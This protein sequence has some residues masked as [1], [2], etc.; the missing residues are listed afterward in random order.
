MKTARRVLGILVLGML[1]I[2]LSSLTAEAAGGPAKPPRVF[3]VNP[4]KVNLNVQ[5]S[6][7]LIG[8]NL[9]PTTRVAIGGVP[10]TTVEAPDTYHLLVRLPDN[11][12]EGIYTVTAANESGSTTAEQ[13]LQVKTETG[14][15]TMNVLLGGGLFALVLLMARMARMPILS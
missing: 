12:Q 1:A 9:T 13:P 5:K 14:L 4:T 10:A 11:L 2:A 7:I 8:Q 6:V 15:N 3:Q